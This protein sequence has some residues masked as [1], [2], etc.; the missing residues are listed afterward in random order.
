MKVPFCISS[1]SHF[2]AWR[3]RFRLPALEA[4]SAVERTHLRYVLGA[5]TDDIPGTFL[6]EPPLSWQGRQE[7]PVL[8]HQVKSLGG[9]T[10]QRFWLPTLV[11]ERAFSKREKLLT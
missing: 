1:F 8:S 5:T 2:L 4:S 6:M 11:G 9:C 10:R 7:C 3:T